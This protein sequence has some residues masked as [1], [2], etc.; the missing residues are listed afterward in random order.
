VQN[1]C[2]NFRREGFGVYK[3]LYKVKKNMTCGPMKP[4]KKKKGRRYIPK[5]GVILSIRFENLHYYLFR[6]MSSYRERV[7]G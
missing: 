7:Y 5:R 1:Y 6:F 3:S 2:S 4:L